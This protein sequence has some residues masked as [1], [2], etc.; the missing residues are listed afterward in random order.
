MIDVIISLGR[1][2]A[3]YLIEWLELL[4][5][6]ISMLEFCPAKDETALWYMYKNCDD[7]KFKAISQKRFICAFYMRSIGK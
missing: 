2:D 7:L 1:K 5:R 4:R 3:H 6:V